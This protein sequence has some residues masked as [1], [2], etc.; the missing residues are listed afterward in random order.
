MCVDVS[1]SCQFFLVITHRQLVVM[2]E[3][4]EPS[5]M[6]IEHL[7]ELHLHHQIFHDRLGTV[8]CSHGAKSSRWAAAEESVSKAVFYHFITYTQIQM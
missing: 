8:F 4:N 1:D 6:L 2:G 3:G 7:C 5:N